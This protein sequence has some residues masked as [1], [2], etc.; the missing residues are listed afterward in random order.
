LKEDKEMRKVLNI[1]LLSSW[2]PNAKNPLEGNFVENHVKALATICKVKV[3]Y[4]TSL[5]NIKTNTI[6]HKIHENYSEL[7]VY[8]PNHKYKIIRLFRKLRAYAIGIKKV[9]KFDLINGNIFFDIGVLVVI[10]SILTRKKI[11]LTEHSSRFF[12]LSSFDKIIFKICKPFI[13]HFVVVSSFLQNALTQ[14]GVP[15]NKIDMIFNAIP[16]DNF[17]IS[18]KNRSDKFTFLHVSTFDLEIKNFAGILR[19]FKKISDNTDNIFLR[20]IGDGNLNKLH[21]MIQETGV[22]ESKL[23]I[24]GRVDNHLLPAI[25]ADADCFVLFSRFENNPLVLL[26]S[27]CCGVPVIASRVGGV[28]DIVNTTNGILV[29]DKD[30]SGLVDAMLYMQQNHAKYNPENLRKSVLEKVKNRNVAN[31]YADLF[32]TIK[33]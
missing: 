32:S 10:T 22:D 25:Y 2:Y 24:T 26:E 7:L 9:G 27:L 30:E 13:S 18:K 17:I 21:Q 5:P 1:L 19:A 4:A 28:S 12:K 16:V 29:E 8:F 33:G 23:I 20:I 14:L 15:T 3:V 6:E 11:I 31:R